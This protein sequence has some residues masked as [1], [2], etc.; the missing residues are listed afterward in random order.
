V[1]EGVKVGG[2]EAGVGGRGGGLV[3]PHVPSMP[4]DDP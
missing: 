2:G 3:F 4:Q 1:E